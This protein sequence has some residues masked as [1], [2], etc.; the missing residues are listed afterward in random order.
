MINKLRF[1][2]IF[3]LTGVGL[4]GFHLMNAVA[5]TPTV[6]LT[7]HARCMLGHVVNERLVPTDETKKLS[8]SFTSPKQYNLYSLSDSIT[9]LGAT[10]LVLQEYPC[11]TRYY[12][13]F[14]K[15]VPNN[16]IAVGNANWN[17]QPRPVKSLS[18]NNAAYKAAITDLLQQNG[19][20]NPKVRILQVLKTDIQGDGKDEVFISATYFTARPNGPDIEH[21]PMYAKKG[22]YSIVAYREV[23]NEKAVTK[24]VTGNIFQTTP[25][26]DEPLMP[27][28]APYEYH[29]NAILDLDGD[30]VMDIVIDNTIHE[31]IG[32]EV[33]SL[34]N[35]KFELVADCGCGF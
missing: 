17:P 11:H 26:S 9:S 27:P 30:G 35:G 33:F 14:D 7:T 13:K 1:V 6:I 20:I 22:D 28:P 24:L 12:V 34:K 16:Y 19:L 23:I 5:A 21:A 18:T 10:E 32:S 31:G 29:I 25:K 2:S 8:K 3:L 4:F 15:D